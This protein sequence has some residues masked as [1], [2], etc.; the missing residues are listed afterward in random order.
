MPHQLQT[1]STAAPTQWGR[2]SSRSEDRV[3]LG[4]SVRV[5]TSRHASA[6]SA[7]HSAHRATLQGCTDPRQ[8]WRRSGE[9]AR[10]PPGK[11]NYRNGCS[12]EFVTP[13][14]AQ[15]QLVARVASG[16]GTM[17]GVRKRLG[18]RFASVVGARSALLR[19]ATGSLP[20][21]REASMHDQKRTREEPTRCAQRNAPRSRELST[22]R[23]PD[24][25]DAHERES[26]RPEGRPSRDT[27]TLQPTAPKFS[28]S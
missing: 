6:H 3:P 7:G 26:R 11:H 8:R 17:P 1:P 23:G 20:R 24:S 16:S 27:R 4:G 12:E 5:G 28:F 18:K 14:G 21:R 9:G 10:E 25:N 2:A 19:R 22:P 15:P 13:R